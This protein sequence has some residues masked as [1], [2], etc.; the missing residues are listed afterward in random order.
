MPD[1]RLL[2]ERHRG[3]ASGTGQPWPGLK[4]LHRAPHA[5]QRARGKGTE[6]HKGIRRV[7]AT[8]TGLVT[9]GLLT[10]VLP[11]QSA[12]A[13]DGAY[14]CPSGYFCGFTGTSGDGEMFKTDKSMATLGTWDNRIRS[15]V[16]RASSYACAYSEPGYSL[17]APDA[18]FLQEEPNASAGEYGFTPFMDRRISSIKF[19][20]TER[21]CHMPAYPQWVTSPTATPAGFGDLDHDLF[22][23]ILARDTAGRLWRLPG[24]HSG[25]L[26]G[27]GWN[28]M[29]AMTRHGDL[30]GDKNEDLL[31]RDKAGQL[32]LYPGTGHGGFATRRPVGGGWQV[33]RQIAATG[34]LTGDGRG[35]LLARDTAGRLWMYP[36]NGRAFGSRKLV[37]GG[38][39][40]MNA[41]TGP[42]D[43][44]GDARPDL[45][46]R[47][48]AGKL[49]LYPGNGRGAFGTRKLVGGGWQIM[50][51]FISVGSYNGGTLND[52]LTIT[53]E[54][55]M[56]GS[57]GW[58]LGYRG[59]GGSTTF[60]AAESV[61]GNWYGLN[62]AW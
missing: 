9:G 14:R 8:V 58:L 6:V 32:W 50:D 51:T 27:S 7:L 18:D 44:T 38:W 53:N 12:Q 22:P 54:G 25:R 36:G 62:G 41:L 21:E 55:Y 43:L 57:P 45:L 23:D 37:G 48:T 15:V 59:T 26:V 47:D 31:A 56:G 33:M 10:A 60:R 29:N 19:V 61:N 16:N 11:A 46:A 30:T 1:I 35:D 24:D 4:G 34:D 17:S 3:K 13:A 5:R 28:S 20:R 42:G 2:A 40:V 39:Q 52:V 49:W